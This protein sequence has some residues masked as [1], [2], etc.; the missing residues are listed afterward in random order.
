MPLGSA[1]PILRI[2]DE[3]VARTFYVDYLG[4]SIDF[5]HRFAPDMPLYLGI[6]RD[7]CEL[8]LSEH[9][10]DTTPGT[11]I[12][13]LVDDI[14]GFW[15]DI[16]GRGHPNVRPGRPSLQPWGERDLTITDPFGNRLT[17]FERVK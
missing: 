7:A 17:F 9:H 14:D 11:R 5:E 2:F 13:V 6:A 8:H 10:G 12:R 4:F 15:Q 16:T 1:T 3:A